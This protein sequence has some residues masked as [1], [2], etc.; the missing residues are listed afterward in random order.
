MK[1]EIIV[2]GVQCF[3]HIVTGEFSNFFV[4]EFNG[5]RYN[6]RKD[7]FIKRGKMF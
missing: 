5:E 7:C 2:L 6:V 4:R 1:I 3:G